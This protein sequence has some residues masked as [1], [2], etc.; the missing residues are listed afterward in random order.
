MLSWL[1]RLM[2]KP[3]EEVRSSISVRLKP[4]AV[5]ILDQIDTSPL[6]DFWKIA[7]FLGMQQEETKYGS[8]IVGDVY[9][10]HKHSSWNV[11][12][13]SP[14]DGIY[15]NGPAMHVF[16]LALGG[17]EDVI[18]VTTN[19]IF[20]PRSYRNPFIMTDLSNFKFIG[21]SAGLNGK[22]QCFLESES[23]RFAGRISYC[24]SRIIGVPS[25][26]RIRSKFAGR[27][28]DLEMLWDP[29]CGIK[30]LNAEEELSETGMGS[31][32]KL[33]G[34]FK[35]P[36]P[37]GYCLGRVVDQL[38]HWLFDFANPMRIKTILEISQ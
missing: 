23:S 9:A 8:F 35:T 21:Y 2:R 30:I 33:E 1:D 26:P 15:I 18:S 29:V 20:P 5:Q 7:S 36:T 14:K 17:M 25:P 38:Q 31:F 24:D 3:E 4:D 12:L 19:S 11:N 37:D 27:V 16:D 34:S 28:S 10:D 6:G 32:L 13:T 22:F